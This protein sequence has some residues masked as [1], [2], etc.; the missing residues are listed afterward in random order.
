VSVKETVELVSTVLLLPS[1]MVTT[2]WDA[3]A[4]PGEPSP[5][6]VVKTSWAG[7]PVAEAP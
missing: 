3:R 5:G 6:W 1:S 4:V 7:L 2:G